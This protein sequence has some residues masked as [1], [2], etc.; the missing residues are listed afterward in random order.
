MSKALK[1]IGAAA[2]VYF[3]IRGMVPLIP[4]P[5]D[6]NE[7][8]HIVRIALFFGISLVLLGTL[9]AGAIMSAR[10]SKRN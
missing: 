3:M 6:A 2:L 10:S 7:P 1:W 5:L 4:I 9:A 8:M